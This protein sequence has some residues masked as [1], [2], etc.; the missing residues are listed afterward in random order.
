MHGCG[1]WFEGLLLCLAA[2][3]SLSF[4][5]EG[6]MRNTVNDYK[7]K[8][9]IKGRTRQLYRK[10]AAL[11]VIC[12]AQPAALRCAQTIKCARTGYVDSRTRFRAADKPWQ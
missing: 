12:F 2:C 11:R 7:K 8:A 10:G 3:L 4:I 6:M 1:S 5:Q 9:G